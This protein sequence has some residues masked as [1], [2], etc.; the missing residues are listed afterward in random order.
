MSNSPEIYSNIIFS[1]L[2]GERTMRHTYPRLSL[3][4]QGIHSI[5]VVTLFCLPFQYIWAHGYLYCLWHKLWK[6]SLFSPA[7]NMLHALVSLHT[8]TA[9]WGPITPSGCATWH[10]FL[11]F[12]LHNSAQNHWG[13]D[14]SPRAK[15]LPV[16]LKLCPHGCWSFPGLWS[17]HN[18]TMVQLQGEQGGDW[19]GSYPHKP[20]RKL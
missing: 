11:Y 14:L 7:P 17:Q 15:T 18:E 20:S 6:A 16:I 9:H 8:C 12:H 5:S 4:N 10:S 13:P 1:F 3:I 19:Q 2:V